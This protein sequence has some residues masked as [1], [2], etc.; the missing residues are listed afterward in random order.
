[1]KIEG[2]EASKY[3]AVR[4]DTFENANKGELVS[5]DEMTGFVSYKDA[6]GETKTLTLGDHAIRI[7]PK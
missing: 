1:M 3:R 6:T 5:A 7:L 2:D 4:L